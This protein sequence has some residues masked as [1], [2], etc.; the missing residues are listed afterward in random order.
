MSCISCWLLWGF[1]GLKTWLF[2][3]FGF[4]LTD[5]FESN[6]LVRRLLVSFKGS[7]L[8]DAAWLLI[9]LKLS[10]ASVLTLEVGRARS[11]CLSC[12]FPLD[13]FWGRS[14]GIYWGLSWVTSIIFL[15]LFINLILFY[16][17]SMVAIYYCYLFWNSFALLL[18]SLSIISTRWINRFSSCICSFLAAFIYY[19]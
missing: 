5:R 8:E 18:N 17:F 2:W 10:K 19:W 3:L 14:A 13:L 9:L 16:K 12:C 6:I 1:N 11:D 4:G 15:L 7:R